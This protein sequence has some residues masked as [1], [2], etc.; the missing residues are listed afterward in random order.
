MSDR[1]QTAA[2]LD[3]AQRATVQ[4]VVECIIPAST[5]GRLPAASAFDV[6]GYVVEKASHL[7]PTL[8]VEIARLDEAAAARFDRPFAKLPLADRESITSALRAD[9]ASF[10]SGLAT[11]TVCCYYQQDRVVLAIGLQARPPFPQG[12]EVKQGDFSLLEPVRSRGRIYRA[13][14]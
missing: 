5:D 1:D 13:V 7:L 8:E 9:D 14:D 12:Y 10:M 4:A 3:D 11:E 2:G 6:A